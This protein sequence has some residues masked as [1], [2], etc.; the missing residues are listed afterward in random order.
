MGKCVAR[1]T[2]S[3]L[4]KNTTPAIF[5]KLTWEN[6]NRVYRLKLQA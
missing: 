4:K 3:V 5:R 2:L 6:A 1:E